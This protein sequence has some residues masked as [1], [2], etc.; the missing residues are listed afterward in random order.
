M[1]PAS[2]ELDTR[3]A[4]TLIPPAECPAARTF[5]DLDGLKEIMTRDTTLFSR[6]LTSKLLTYATGRTMQVGDRAEI[7]RIADEIEQ[8]NGGLKDLVSLVIQSSIFQ[9][10]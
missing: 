2:G 10:K 4:T 1:P 8:R 6:N 5:Q 9:R 7:E 3:T